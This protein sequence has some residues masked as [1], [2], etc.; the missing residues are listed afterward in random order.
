MAMAINGLEIVYAI[1][2]RHVVERNGD[3]G[4]F[5]RVPT[6]SGPF[7]DL[8][9]PAERWRTSKTTDVAAIQV[10]LPEH[11]ARDIVWL[12]ESDFMTIQK[13]E[14]M[15]ARKWQMGEG[16]EVFYPGLFTKFHEGGNRMLP[17]VRFGHIALM[18]YEPLPFAW[19]RPGRV[20]KVSFQ[21]SGYL[22]EAKSWHGFSGSPVFIYYPIEEYVRVSILPLVKNEIEGV[23]L[24]AG[25]GIP[26]GGGRLEPKPERPGLTGAHL[27]GLVSSYWDYDVDARRKHSVHA[28]LAIVVPADDILTLLKED[29]FMKE[30]EKIAREERSRRPTAKPASAPDDLPPGPIDRAGFDRALRKTSRRLSPPGRGK[31][32]T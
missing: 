30:R 13:Q 5:L 16:D 6:K 17:V 3:S 1:T 32:G 24:I 18:P 31:K 21:A 25:H 26:F 27:L 2:A 11:A 23:G 7:Q 12:S 19:R 29:R 4:L 28:G 22:I 10:E 15:K 9:A 14:E 20:T 8:P